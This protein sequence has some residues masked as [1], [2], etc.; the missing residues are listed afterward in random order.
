MRPAV[1]PSSP[2]PSFLPSLLNSSFVPLK[3]RHVSNFA[4]GGEWQHYRERVRWSG[5]SD[6]ESDGIERVNKTFY[7]CRTSSSKHWGAEVHWSLLNIQHCQQCNLRTATFRANC[8]DFSSLEQNHRL[9]IPFKCVCVS[10]QI[11]SAH[12]FKSNMNMETLCLCMWVVRKE[13]RL[14]ITVFQLPCD[15]IISKWLIQ[16]N[17]PCS[18]M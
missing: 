11:Y 13:T 10:S 12:I 7:R 8:A 1:P 17:S 5:S 16:A 18:L 2:D 4:Q 14:Y 6:G 15:T 3:A 9:Q